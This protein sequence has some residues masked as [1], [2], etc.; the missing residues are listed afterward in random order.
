M[1][2]P[3]VVHVVA[4]PLDLAGRER[5]PGD[6]GVLLDVDLVEERGVIGEPRVGMAI[7]TERHVARVEQV[8]HR[9]ARP[10]DPRR[11]IDDR[12]EELILVPHRVDRRGDLAQRP[13]R[14]GRALEGLA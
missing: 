14:L 6:A 7:A 2:E 9:A 4:A 1:P 11:G 10:Q 5:Q 8:D 12:L 13:F 3:R